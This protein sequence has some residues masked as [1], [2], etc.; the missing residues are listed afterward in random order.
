L[1]RYDDLIP[2]EIERYH[3]KAAGIAVLL[4]PMTGD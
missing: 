3:E 1:E 4:A 2:A